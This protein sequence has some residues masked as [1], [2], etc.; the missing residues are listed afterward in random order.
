MEC[1]IWKNS[2]FWNTLSTLF[3]DDASTVLLTIRVLKK[4]MIKNLDKE[5]YFND[6]NIVNSFCGSHIDCNDTSFDS[7]TSSMLANIIVSLDGMNIDK[8]DCIDLL[9]KMQKNNFQ[10][11]DGE[12][13]SIGGAVYPVGA[14]LNHSCEPNCILLYE[15][16][17]V[18]KTMKQYIRVLKNIEKGEQITHSYVDSALITSDRQK[19]LYKQYQ[20]NC[21]CPKCESSKDN[22]SSVDRILTGNLSPSIS[23]DIQEKLDRADSFFN[24]SESKIDPN[25]RIKLLKEC[26]DLRIS[27]LHQYSLKVFMVHGRMLDTYLELDDRES[28]I[29]SCRKIIECYEKS[30]M[31]GKPENNNVIHPMI[32]LQYFTLGDILLEQCQLA[33]ESGNIYPQELLKQT[34][35]AYEKAYHILKITH[36]TSHNI[37]KI[38]EEHL[39]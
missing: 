31:Y 29:N 37:V 21:A 35:Y 17:D 32:G 34:R 19:H 10:I 11:V 22:L 39:S 6:W 15:Y 27:Y 4:K 3:V 23:E 5:K 26:L 1:S 33:R 36:G 2:T 9:I 8:E 14:M 16:D 30:G 25:E 12:F 7:Q 38:I 13:R 18:D 28:A 20:F 24:E